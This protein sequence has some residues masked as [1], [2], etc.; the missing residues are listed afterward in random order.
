M[1]TTL[2]VLLA[3][4]MTA[5]WC[6]AQDPAGACSQ[7]N[8]SDTP[9]PV[10]FWEVQEHAN[11]GHGFG[12]TLGGTCKYTNTGS[13]AGSPCASAC[14]ASAFPS[15]YGP[16]GSEQGILNAVD[17]LYTHYL[18]GVANV[19]YAQAPAGGAAIQ[20]G[21]TFAA[22][23]R[24]C[25][26][27][28]GVAVTINGSSTGVGMSV[29]FPA[30]AIMA[31]ES[32]L[33][34]TC[35]SEAAPL[36][37]GSSPGFVCAAGTGDGGST[38]PTC[39]SNGSWTCNGTTECTTPP[40]QYVCDEGEY[41]SPSCGPSGWY[42]YT[43]DSPIIIDADG[44]GFHLTNFQGGVHFDITGDGKPQ[45]I[46]W[47]AA[48]STNGWLALPHDGKVTSGKQLFGNFTP[49]PPS[50]NP[51]GFLALAVYDQPENGGN[52]DGVIDWHD[53]VWPNLRIWIDKNHDGIA[54][55][56]E[57]FTLPSLGINSLAVAYVNSK[58][59]DQF[60]NQ[61]RDKGRVNPDGAP[62]TDHVDRTMY[63]VFLLSG[64][65]GTQNAKKPS[66]LDKTIATTEHALN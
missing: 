36:A 44:T 31:L 53:A 4:L 7:F 64:Q 22:A 12:D 47:T 18:N 24:S 56:D 46:S 19:G 8:A 35:A 20:C 60:G 37:C 27:S 16:T 17:A 41:G 38:S 33:T 15:G 30:D 58:Y 2:F 59:V 61:F 9:V 62:S 51:N 23:V 26:I 10:N 5:V 57:L 25:L 28:C 49:Q 48:G 29:S 3:I 66:A 42:C 52:A 50:D 21:A 40:N 1:R 65:S 34:T 63:D 32:P 14:Q 39:E 54:Q 43:G 6:A 55:P 45:Q 11:G 13:T